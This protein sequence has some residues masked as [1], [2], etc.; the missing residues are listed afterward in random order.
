MKTNRRTLLLSSAAAGAT[1]LF[2]LGLYKGYFSNEKEN[3]LPTGMIFGGGQGLHKGQKF[4]FLAAINLNL[5]NPA[6]G[7]I[8][9]S[10]LPHGLAFNPIDSKKVCLFEKKGPG[11]CELDL[12]TGKSIKIETDRGRYFYGHGVYVSDSTSLNQNYKLLSTETNLN[13]GEGVIVIRDA[14]TLKVEGQF[15]SYG[16]NPHDCLL[17]DNG[18][19]LAIT[20]GGAPLGQKPLPSVTYVDVKTQKLLK[21]FEL[22]DPRFNAGHLAISNEKDLAVVSAPRLGLPEL[23][24]GAISILSKSSEDPN[25]KKL[26]TLTEPKQIIDQLKS[27]TLSL[28]I[29]E[30]RDLLATTSPV[31]GLVTFWNIKSGRFISSVDLPSPRGLILSKDRKYFLISCDQ[32]ARLV[33]INAETLKVAKDLTIPK[34]GFSGSHLYTI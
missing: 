4:H 3:T 30:K 11:A 14:Q 8:P 28:F 26:V 6:V 20:N 22:Q 29:D 25:E 27:E 23:G 18:S 16:S 19:V 32:D 1:G 7:H 9:V 34:A 2:S 17:I 12:A 5:A 33:F 31:G 15:P 13:S 21:I 24:S 10:F